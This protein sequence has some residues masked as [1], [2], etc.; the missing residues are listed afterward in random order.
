MDVFQNSGASFHQLMAKLHFPPSLV[1]FRS[2]LFAFTSLANSQTLRPT[3]GRYCPFVLMKSNGPGLRSRG[4]VSRGTL[5]GVR[6]PE[7]TLPPLLEH[8][9][10]NGAFCRNPWGSRNGHLL[11]CRP[12]HSSVPKRH[13]RFGMICRQNK[14]S[15]VQILKNSECRSQRP[16]VAPFWEGLV[17]SWFMNR[18]M[19]P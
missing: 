6:L 9:G 5:S 3:S 7:S 14:Q 17:Q 2:I 16:S 12:L 19:F 13:L 4:T 18:L 1:R 11:F 10:E 15:K 8:W